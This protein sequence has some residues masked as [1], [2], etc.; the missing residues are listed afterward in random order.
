MSGSSLIDHS[1]NGN[2]GQING[3]T[4]QSNSGLRNL[5]FDGV[6]D[7][8]SV[9]HSS[10]FNFGTDDFTIEAQFKTSVIPTTSWTAIF[11]KHNTANW[12][13]KEIFLGIVGT[14]GFP[15]FDLSDGTGYFERATG[16]TNVCDGLVHTIRGVR[17]GNELKI[18]VDG[19]LQATVLASI[20]P[21][22]TNPINIG[23]SS[24][25]N[26]Y[27]YFNGTINRISLWKHPLPITPVEYENTPIVQ[28]FN[29]LQNFPNPFNPSTTINYWIPE[30]SNVSL[31]V[32]DILGKELI[33][34]IN[35]AKAPG[36]YSVQFHSNNFPSGIYL[37]CLQTDNFVETRKMILLK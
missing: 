16:T 15:S 10:V 2:N 29:L 13:D 5:S 32:Y 36:N 24:Y 30:R 18:Y 14:T 3:A 11:S 6:N 4:W 21:D 1:G 31:K 17:Q 28:E 20:N 35:E 25:N 34:L 23:R 26:G 8:V 33:T 37:Y 22:N 7:Y 9:P 12:H 19:D 27:G